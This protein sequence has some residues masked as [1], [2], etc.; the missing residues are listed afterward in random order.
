MTEQ[1]IWRPSRRRL[2]DALLTA[3]APV[4]ACVFALGGLSLWTAYGRAGT[5]ARIAVSSG[6]VLL[7][8][9]AGTETAAFFDVS[10]L[11]GADDRLLRVT[12]GAARGEITLSE[13]HMAGGAAAYKTDVDAVVVPA[14]GE[15]S[16]SPAGVDVT[17]RAG[18]GWQAGDLV[19]FTLHF[20]H[21]APVRTIAVVVRPSD[22]ARSAP[23]A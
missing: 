6:R 1:N 22:S 5:P 12:S 20:E 3:L 18:T 9:G 21:S 10:N 15:L 17:L 16:M 2:T 8:Y 23:P 7:P 19:A 11:G 14:G 4:A 13:H